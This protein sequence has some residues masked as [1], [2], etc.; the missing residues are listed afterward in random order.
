V[1]DL[2]AAEAAGSATSESAHQTAVAFSSFT[3]SSAGALTVVL[4]GAVLGIARVL[5]VWTLLRELL[6]RALGAMPTAI[7]LR[8]AVILL[9][10]SVRVTVWVLAVLETALLGRA[11]V[12]LRV[13]L[14][15]RLIAVSRSRWGSISALLRWVRRMAL[16]LVLR[17]I[18][19]IAL[20]RRLL[21]TAVAAL[22]GILVIG[23]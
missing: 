2:V 15:A 16:L 13:L 9:L 19:R 1:A 20:L 3:G 18:A 4:R 22:L 17:R 10:S 6:L 12:A 8:V 5:A 7:I 21:I 23:V 14:V 11:V